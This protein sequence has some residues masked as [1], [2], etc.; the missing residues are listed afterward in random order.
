MGMIVLAMDHPVSHIRLQYIIRSLRWAY[1]CTNTIRRFY[2]VPNVLSRL[3]CA[4]CA[5]EPK[6]KT[7]EVAMA[8]SHGGC[9]MDIYGGGID[10]F[11]P[12]IYCILYGDEMI[13]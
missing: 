9:T 1:L 8:K 7:T 10:R 13:V 12:N 6:N 4:A 3:L 5:Q 2:D 11:I